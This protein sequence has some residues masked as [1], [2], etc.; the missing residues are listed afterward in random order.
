MKKIFLLIFWFQ[1]LY[2]SAQ[3]KKVAILDFENTSNSSEY[4]SLGKALSNMLI[5][6]LANNIHP[7]KIE[8]FERLQ[9]NKILKEQ[10][11]QMTEGFDQEAAVNFGKL[12]GVD[13]IFLGSVFIMDGSC[14]IN[15]RLIDVET[16]KIILAKD[17]EGKTEAFL[18]LKTELAV[19]LAKELNNPITI[20]TRYKDPLTSLSTLTQYGKVLY[21]IDQGD[22]DKA[23]QSRSLFEE[24]TPD[25]KYF[26]DIKYDIQKLKERISELETVTEVLTN[27]FELGDKAEMNQD[28]ENAIKFFEKF[29]NNP[30]SIGFTENKKLYA[31][32]KL[33]L[34]QY[35]MGNYQKSLSNSII[36]QKIYPYFPEANEIQLLSL[37]KLNEKKQAEDK[38]NFII[39]SLT[40]TNE[41]NFTRADINPKL[42]WTSLDG[43]YYGL[44][45]DDKFSIWLYLSI[46]GS[47]KYKTGYG[48]SI[49]NEVQINK[50]LHKEKLTFLST[51]WRQKKTLSRYKTIENKLLSFNDSLIFSSD[52]ILN[53]YKL[54]LTYAD[55]LEI[56]GN[57][58]KYELHLKKEI[59]RMENFGL[60]C[61]DNKRNLEILC[62]CDKHFEIVSARENIARNQGHAFKKI[63]TDKYEEVYTKLNL[64]NSYKDFEDNFPIIY[65]EFIFDYLISLI[66]TNSISQG[67]ALYKQITNEYVTDRKSYFYRYYWDIILGFREITNE[68]SSWDPLP[69]DEFKNKLNTKIQRILIKKENP[70]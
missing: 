10:E 68:Y 36:A 1:F 55:C 21:Y 62:E 26:I 11:L 7:N 39:D 25:F 52:Q 49:E 14:N 53:F 58:K 51:V 2:I 29:L 35:K 37:I 19:E 63:S 42:M 30:G 33:A 65:G 12:C 8:F 60:E 40:F 48:S 56:N 27:A 5:T 43:I 28:Y 15:S 20:D 44:P 13:Y 34:S 70:Y 64:S 31:Y 47:G 22:F 4:E 3:T 6:D 67:N 46:R 61:D 66:K 69:K 50:V 38:Y 16:S 24:T 54:S 23:E 32:S 45:Q 57:S 18:G 17:V 41:L 9:I 59:N